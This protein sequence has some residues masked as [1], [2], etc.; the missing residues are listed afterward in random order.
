[1]RAAKIN[2]DGWVLEPDSGDLERAGTRIR[3][4]E[5]ALQVLLELIAAGGG[6]VT[7]QQ[8]TAKLWPKGVVDFDTGLN[9][10][11]RKL[12]VALGDTADTPRYI[13]TLPR[14]GYRFIAIVDAHPEVPVAAI[15][16]VPSPL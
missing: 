6:L 15:P 8:L 16:A 13:E 10:V 7:R 4:Q 5:Q 12:R 3:L 2:F 1:M 11:I 14:K 9:T